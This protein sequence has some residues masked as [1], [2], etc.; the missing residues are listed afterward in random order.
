[1]ERQPAPYES[2]LTTRTAR[3][4]SL[5]KMT[6]RVHE[7]WFVFHGY[8]QLAGYFIQHF[9]T[10]ATPERFIVA[11]EGLSRFYLGENKWERVGASWM[12]REAREEEIEDQVKFLDELYNHVLFGWDDVR[13]VLFGFS[14]GVATAW[15]WANLSQPPVS[16]LVAWAGNFPA[17][18]EGIRA[19]QPRVHAVVGTEDPFYSPEREQAFRAGLAHS[20]LPYSLRTFSGGHVVHGPTLE[21]L[22]E[23][24]SGVQTATT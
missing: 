8:G 17:E 12:T 1:M 13:V 5:G 11:P 20:G 3:Y 6:E 7:L 4:C 2:F 9:E 15:R 16:D 24:I 14:Q 22:A 23:E 19:L 18:F 10:L 21:V